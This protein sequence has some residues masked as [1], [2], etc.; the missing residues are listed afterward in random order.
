LP[1]ESQVP[2]I[3]QNK[4]W[5]GVNYDWKDRGDEWSAAFGGPLAHWT[6]S[7]LPRISA[8]LPTSSLVEIAPGHG[9]FTRFLL[10]LCRQYTGYD[11]NENCV[12]H[13]KKDFVASRH[14][15]F[16]QND[17]KSLFANSPGSVDLVF[18]YDSLVHA[19]QDAMK[20]YVAEILR[21]LK[22]MTGVAFLHHSNFR[23]I[24]KDSRNLEGRGES[25][26][27]KY[28]EGEIVAGG[29]A[30]LIQETIPW[31]A[32]SPLQCD[33]FTLF[34]RGDRPSKK[35]TI[36]LNNPMFTFEVQY[37]KSLFAR[38]INVNS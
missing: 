10:P 13:C 30:V 6:A 23:A 27:A 34:S 22:P 15:E 16:Y 5:W 11:L 18:S 4:Q 1:E 26:D 7:V 28:V 12:A 24:A 20:G 2:T 29:G 35:P 33:C 8:F 37:I 32:C 19:E 17:G 14:A 3:D 25:V 9:R 36:H 21:L 38:Y 31:G